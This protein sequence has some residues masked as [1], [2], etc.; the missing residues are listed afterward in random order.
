[1]IDLFFNEG[2]L[3]AE[4]YEDMLRNQIVPAIR[5]NNSCHC[6]RRHWEH[7]V[8]TK[9]CCVTHTWKRC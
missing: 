9:W 6:W 7:L 8:P 1:L 3:N 4:I 5:A 2:N